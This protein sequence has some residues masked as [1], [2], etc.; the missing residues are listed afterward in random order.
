MIATYRL[1][2]DRVVRTE[3]DGA[4]PFNASMVWMDMSNPSDAEESAAEALLGVDLPTRAE[5]QEI[6]ISS[7]IYQENGSLFLTAILLSKADSENP[8]VGSVTFVLTPTN[9]ISIRYIEP[10]S[11]RTY[12]QI[13]Q[14]TG[15]V[16]C[17][18]PVKVLG[19]LLDTIV[20]RIADILEKI[21][22]DRLHFTNDIQATCRE[23][24]TLFCGSG[25]L[26]GL[27]RAYW[28]VRRLN[29]QSAG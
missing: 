16:G 14:K 1:E 15:R 22:R 10:Q 29:H 24:R 21:E 26:G 12:A 13:I 8:E 11:F 27:D 9:L 3:W 6:E 7:R 5:M 18:S 28:A 2:N 4:S 23:D 17:T 25:E 20:D 19:G